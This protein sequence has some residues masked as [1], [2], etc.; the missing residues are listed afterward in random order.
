MSKKE[1]QKKET[2][3]KKVVKEDADSPT[4]EQKKSLKRKNPKDG[5]EV[6]DDGVYFDVI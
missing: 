3:N 4:S 5:I 2:P 6:K 1:S